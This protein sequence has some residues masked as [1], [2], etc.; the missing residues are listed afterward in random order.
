MKEKMLK[1]GS[2]KVPSGRLGQVDSPSGRITFHSRLPNGQGIGKAS[3]LPTESLKEQT[4]TCPGQQKFR[5]T[6]P[7]G[8]LEFKFLS[9]PVKVVR[10]IDHVPQL[11][12]Q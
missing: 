1:Q 4:K 6:C 9:N 2:K 12:V 3:H 10:R 7:K 11:C 5:A 8:K